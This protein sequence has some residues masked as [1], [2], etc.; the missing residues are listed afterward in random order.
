VDGVLEYAEGLRV[1]YRDPGRDVLF[2]FG[3]GLGHTDWEY[4]SIEVD[5]DV[6]RVRLR[7]AGARAGREV[8][9]LYASR[10]D[11]AIE[12]PPRWLAGFAGVAADPGEEVVAEIAVPDRALAHWDVAAGAFAVAPGTFVLEAGRSCRDLRVSAP[13]SRRPTRSP[14]R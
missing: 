11:G 12:R 13:T 1:G 4:R 2:A 3:H 10:P 7:N 6:A 9:Q 5:G 8:V 14:D